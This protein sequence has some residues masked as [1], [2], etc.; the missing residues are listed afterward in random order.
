MS[1][2]I[3]AARQNLEEALAP[4]GYYIARKEDETRLPIVF[5]DLG[6]FALGLLAW[7]LVEYVKGLI[8][9]RA[10]MDASRLFEDP[11]LGE[12]QLRQ[13]LREVLHELR[14]IKERVGTEQL[15]ESHISEND[16]VQQL[17]ASGLSKRAA[18]KAARE[19]RPVLESQVRLVI[20]DHR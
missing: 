13:T 1:E 3:E 19:L 16:L 14:E 17:V 5:A 12:E 4:Y 2:T 8:Q 20:F 11:D 18:R 15:H 7:G 10:R 6:L 9:E